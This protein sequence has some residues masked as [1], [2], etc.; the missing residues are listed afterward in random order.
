MQNCKMLCL[1]FDPGRKWRATLERRK[2]AKAQV[3]D[4][5][6]QSKEIPKTPAKVMAPQK[7]EIHWNLIKTKLSFPTPG[8]SQICPNQPKPSGPKKTYRSGGYCKLL[9]Q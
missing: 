2:I 8:I 6:L 4:A 9:R 3:E 5:I 1:T 7:E